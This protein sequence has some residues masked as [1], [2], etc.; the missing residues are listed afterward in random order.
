ME[1]NKG[2][3]KNTFRYKPMRKSK[4]SRKKENVGKAM[5]GKL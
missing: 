4:A 1:E 5:R 2:N 3:E